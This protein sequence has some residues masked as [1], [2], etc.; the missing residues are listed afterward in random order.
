MDIEINFYGCVFY[1][2]DLNAMNATLQVPDT[3]IQIED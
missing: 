2:Q 1:I 3:K